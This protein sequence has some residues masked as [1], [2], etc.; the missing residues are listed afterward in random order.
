MR[1]PSGSLTLS[2]LTNAVSRPAS[3]SAADI[4]QR[5]EAVDKQ[6][7]AE[8]LHSR[9]VTGDGN[10]Y[11]RALSVC[12]FG[13]EG[14]HW[15]LRQ[16]IVEQISTPGSILAGVT[17]S[18]DD[19]H[20]EAVRGHLAQLKKNGT[21]AGEDII[22]AT[23]IHLKRNIHIYSGTG[24]SSPLVYSAPDSAAVNLPN[25]FLAYYEPGHYKAVVGLSSP[26]AA[27]HLLPNAPSFVSTNTVLNA[28]ATPSA[29]CDSSNVFFTGN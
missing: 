6:L 29:S 8:R 16:N 24:K 7:A 20:S 9:D 5:N 13:H 28:S 2:A 14:E 17:I 1:E 22:L 19:L 27:S 25:I 15:L 18:D 12:L 3:V 4:K 23:A 10:C 11:F 26:P 21:W